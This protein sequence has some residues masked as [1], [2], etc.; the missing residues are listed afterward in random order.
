MASKK[1]PIKNRDRA[2]C[3]TNIA[4]VKDGKRIV[5]RYYS[6]EPLDGIIADEGKRTLHVTSRY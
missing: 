6:G 3:P 4:T 1:P 2:I 5:R